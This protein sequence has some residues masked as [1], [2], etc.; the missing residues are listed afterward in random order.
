MR[1][2]EKQ[3]LRKLHLTTAYG[4]ASPRGEAKNPDISAFCGNIRVLLVSLRERYISCRFF[5]GKYRNFMSKQ[6]EKWRKMMYNDYVYQK[7]E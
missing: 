3:L 4:G 7:W 1:W 5:V 6:V 2:K